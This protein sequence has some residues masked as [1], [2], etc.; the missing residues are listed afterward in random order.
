MMSD[1]Q[2][3]AMHDF[4]KKAGLIVKHFI[5][6]VWFLLWFCLVS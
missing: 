3:A 5:I 1:F 6:V 4:H 2:R